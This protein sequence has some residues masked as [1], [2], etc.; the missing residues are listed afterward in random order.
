MEY[1]TLG[2]F[3]LHLFQIVVQIAN[4]SNFICEHHQVCHPYC[5]ERQR[6]SCSR[7]MAAIKK[8]YESEKNEEPETPPSSVGER[9]DTLR[10]KYK[11]RVRRSCVKLSIILILEVKEIH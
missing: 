8:V 4:S 9:R 2:T 5:Y 3:S 10:D 7:P 1:N 6:R 11:R